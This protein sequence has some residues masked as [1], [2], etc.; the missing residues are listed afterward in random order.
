MKHKLTKIML[1]III[2]TTILT[3][4]FIY[5]D[6]QNNQKIIND[7]SPIKIVADNI[8]DDLKLNPIDP[9][10]AFNNQYQ[11][12]SNT[13][14]IFYNSDKKPDLPDN[15][16]NSMIVLNNNIASTIKLPKISYDILKEI[17]QY[18]LDI[19]STDPSQ[20]INVTINYDRFDNNKVETS[21][22]SYF[23]INDQVFLNNSHLQTMTC[24]LDS[25]NCPFISIDNY[26]NYIY[27]YNLGIY[28][29]IEEFFNYNCKNIDQN[30][31]YEKEFNSG[32]NHEN[33]GITSS[34]CIQELSGKYSKHTNL[35]N[36]LNDDYHNS[37]L[38]WFQINGIYEK[39]NFTD[40]LSE[41]YYIFIIYIAFILVAFFSIKKILS[42][43][44]SP[45]IP[46][47]EPQPANK[48]P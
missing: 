7:D 38:A 2:G 3:S 6:Y 16:A 37:Y 9:D 35:V 10:E 28:E 5:H 41:H 20:G 45:V 1:I 24:Q 33:N 34:L 36:R 43:Q 27:S 30:G 11:R 29:S 26:M 15:D 47:E 12:L 23:A 40:Y 46:V 31:Y 22:L 44:V 18:L 39:Y 19:V 25:F 48:L 32:K 17:S 13:H 21:K 14:Y 4:F 8:N 42:H